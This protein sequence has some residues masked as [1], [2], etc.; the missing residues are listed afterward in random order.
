MTHITALTNDARLRQF[1]DSGD[2]DAGLP[3]IPRSPN[4][5]GGAPSYQYVV[6]GDDHARPTADEGDVVA[7]EPAARATS[8][9]LYVIDVMG[10][11]KLVRLDIHPFGEAPTATIRYINELY[12]DDEIS[13]ELA[14]SLVLGRPVG[15]MARI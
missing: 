2:G 9:G 1:L 5:G 11:P 10:E 8:D 7:I 14:H 4:R 13:L 12:S 3:A 6:L 15:L